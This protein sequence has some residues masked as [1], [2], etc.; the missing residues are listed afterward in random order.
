MVCLIEA[1]PSET[2]NS[3][4]GFVTIEAGEMWGSINVVIAHCA[5]LTF[6]TELQ[7]CVS[8][9]IALP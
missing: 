3:G 5:Q 9:Y 8:Y 4:L 1:V 2:Y 6:F 7:S